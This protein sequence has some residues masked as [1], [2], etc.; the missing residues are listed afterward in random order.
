[1][2]RILQSFFD[3]LTER[4]VAMAGAMVASAVDVERTTQHAEQ[5]S[6]LEDLARQMEADGKEHIAASI[7]SR[8]TT[9]TID[10]PGHNVDRLI[11]S[12]VN[13]SA[14]RRLESDA[15]PKALP[16]PSTP[17]PKKNRRTSSR[18]SRTSVLPPLNEASS[19]STT[20]AS[21]ANDDSH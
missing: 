15:S 7:R 8:I 18:S 5:Q 1:M 9:Q 14:V 10:N 4:I 13:E 2:H 17:K 21:E 11:E 19:Q 20:S 12:L 16:T 6:Q 3:R